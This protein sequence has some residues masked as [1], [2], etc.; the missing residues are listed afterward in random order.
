MVLLVLEES[1][2]PLL[3]IQCQDQIRKVVQKEDGL[4]F[5]QHTVQ[6]AVILNVRTQ[7]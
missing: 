5:S 2:E 6:Y 7:K 3:H 1:V 4:W